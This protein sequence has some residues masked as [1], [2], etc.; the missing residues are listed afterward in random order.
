[1]LG[2][3]PVKVGFFIIN[4]TSFYFVSFFY[5]KIIPVGR[6]AGGVLHKIFRGK[7]R[8]KKQAWKVPKYPWRER[9]KRNF[10]NRRKPNQA[11]KENNGYRS[12]KSDRRK[13]KM[14]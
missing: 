5:I 1:M 7:E 6:T 12:L 8:K 11:E 9:G 2:P 10:P 4:R 14:T 3:P 13:K